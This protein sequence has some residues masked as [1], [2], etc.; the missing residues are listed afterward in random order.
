ML[1]PGGSFKKDENMTNKVEPLFLMLAFFVAAIGAEAAGKLRLCET[2]RRYVE[3]WNGTPLFLVG[4]HAHNTDLA[5]SIGYE[6]LL[7]LN[8]RN[9]VNYMRFFPVCA[10]VPESGGDG[11][12]LMFERVGPQKVDLGKWDEDF[13]PRVRKYLVFMRDHGIIAHISLFEGCLP[14]ESHPFNARFNV[15]T[16]LGNV[17]RDGDGEGYEQG[18][19]FDYQALTNPDAT[20][21]QKALKYYQ[22]RIVGRILAESSPFPNVMYEIGNELPNPG[23]KWVQYWVKFIR[24]RCDNLITY[25]GNEGLTEPGFDGA[26]AH[27][28]REDNVRTPFSNEEMSRERFVASSSDGGE[29]T[30]VGSDAGRRCLWS[31]FTAGIGGWLNYSTDFYSV[32]PEKYYYSPESPRRYNLRKGLYYFNA[33]GFI[34]D[35]GL[36]FPEMSPRED[37]II[38]KPDGVEAYCLAGKGEYVVYLAGERLG[39]ELELSLQPASEH[40][41]WYNPRTGAF[42]QHVSVRPG[43]NVLTV[44]VEKQD[45][46]LYVGRPRTEMRVNHIEAPE[47]SAPTVQLEVRNIGERLI[48]QSLRAEHSTDCLESFRPCQDVSVD[49]GDGSRAPL[50]IT[51]AAIPFGEPR[52]SR[53]WVRV[54][55]PTESGRWARCTVPVVG[56]KR[57]WT[58]LGEGDVGDGLYH[59]QNNDGCTVP[60]FEEGRACRRNVDPSGRTP[61]RYLYFSVDNTFA[62]AGEPKDFLITVTYLDVPDGLLELHYDAEGEGLEN[63]YRPGGVVK[64]TGT[65]EWVQQTFTVHD[66]YFGDRQNARADFRFFIG[67]DKVAYISRVELVVGEAKPTEE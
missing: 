16:D 33:V 46:V 15:N 55:V 36:P 67:R 5:S 57:A 66:A 21:Q 30:N 10:G 38:R 53:N 7:E 4:Y 24:D 64:F 56:S 26:T 37:V 27:V 60:A 42:F 28:G 47:T 19:F 34:H 49:G 40:A 2:N 43:E 6:R 63:A 14:W 12:W 48:K 3:D 29:I 65:N 52:A 62:Y 23:M 8:A 41:Y 22:E 17:D 39:G 50:R 25:N 54:A 31:V 32:D 1:P 35:W 18:E 45:V 59:V 9:R 20:P 51:I 61:D 44:P 58:E 11:K 13:W